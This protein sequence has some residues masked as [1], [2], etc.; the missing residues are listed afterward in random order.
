MFDKIATI[1]LF[2][3]DGSVVTIACPP[4]GRKPTIRLTGT[5][6]SQD[7]ILQV[8]VR[9]TNFVTDVPLSEYTHVAGAPLG[10]G[11]HITVAAGY[12]GNV[13][14][15]LEGEAMNA[16]QETPGPDGVTVLQMLVGSFTDWT[17]KKLNG[18]WAAGTPLYIPP[19][20]GV[21]GEVANALG[22]TLIYYA[23]P[24]LVLPCNVS[25]NGLAKELI[26][27]LKTIFA[28]K[29]PHGDWSGLEVRPD[30]ANLIALNRDT[31]TGLVYELNYISLA[32]H[33]AAGYNIQAP[34]VPAIRPQDTV[35]VDPSYFR[36]T[37]GG[38]VVGGTGSTFRVIS[39]AFDFCT[40]DDTNL[41]SLVLVA[42]AEIPRIHTPAILPRS[43]IRPM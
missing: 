2:R 22:L 24:S 40:T 18:N 35:K 1:S 17:T 21:L 38:S 31:G 30:G 26:A 39:N 29:G 43:P 41:M 16:Y 20:G 4:G 34:W 33:T 37:F 42:E 7:K 25:S 8:E 14:T 13:M 12:A 5:M 9:V 32:N 11:G 10:T 23:D 36:Q 3:A 27:K 28:K 19:A 15:N 6:L